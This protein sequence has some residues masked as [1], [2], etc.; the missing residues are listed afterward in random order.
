MDTEN[1]SRDELTPTVSPVVL[2]MFAGVAVSADF[3]MWGLAMQ[4]TSPEV[5]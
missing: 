5:W 4:L 2:G 1:P 3:G